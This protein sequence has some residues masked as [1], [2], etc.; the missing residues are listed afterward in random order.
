MVEPSGS[1]RERAR[2]AIAVGIAVARCLGPA[3]N[4]SPRDQADAITSALRARDYDH[5]VE[6]TREALKASPNDPQ[7][8]TLQG[9]A[10]STE[11][12]HAAAR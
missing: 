7:I 10:L 4:A 1:D 12:R 2:F 5:A 11:G 9:I 3:A 6:L 8:W